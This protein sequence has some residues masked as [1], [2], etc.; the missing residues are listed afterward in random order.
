MKY[1]YHTEQHTATIFYI[2]LFAIMV[3]GGFLMVIW[4]FIIFDDLERKPSI[5]IIDSPAVYDLGTLQNC[6]SSSRI[7][8]EDRQFCRTKRYTFY[9]SE[10]S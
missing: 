10:D 7:R 1:N 4:L 3:I 9:L 2:V 8:E 5:E 6:R